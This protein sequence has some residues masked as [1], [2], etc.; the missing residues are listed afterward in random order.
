MLE[1]IHFNRLFDLPLLTKLRVKIV[2]ALTSDKPSHVLLDEWL[3]DDLNNTRSRF[4]I[5][6]QKHIDKIFHSLTISVRYW[7]LFILYNLKNESKQILCV[8]GVFKGAEFIEDATQSPDIRLVSVR[9]IL[10]HLWRHVVRC[11]L[12]RHSMILGAL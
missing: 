9:L 12:H 11:T 8:K 4:F 1:L 7:L 10:A 2:L 5:F 6:D 3:L